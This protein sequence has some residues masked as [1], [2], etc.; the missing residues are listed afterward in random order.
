MTKFEALKKIT[1]LAEIYFNNAGHESNTFSKNVIV[2][3][4]I[5]LIE[6]IVKEF[7]PKRTPLDLPL[8]VKLTK[9]SSPKEVVF[10]GTRTVKRGGEGETIQKVCRVIV[11]VENHVARAY[12]DTKHIG[13]AHAEMGNGKFL[14]MAGVGVLRSWLKCIEH[15]RDCRARRKAKAKAQGQQADNNKVEEG[16]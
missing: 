7:A 5:A 8:G 12:Y 16:K 11:D 6:R 13:D 4:A 10:I 3:E 9:Y 14:E 2:D 15:A 1:H